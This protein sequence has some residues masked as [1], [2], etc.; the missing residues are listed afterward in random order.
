MQ[1]IKTII[2]TTEQLT[3]GLN[4]LNP[5]VTTDNCNA[6]EADQ[7]FEML[8]E[9]VNQQYKAWY[10]RELYRLPRT[11]II[12]LASLAQADGSDP[13]RLFSFLLKRA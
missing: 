6:Q 1:A 8:P 7:I 3:T 4:K 2:Q 9:L 13:R 10:C 11:K 12:E 5:I